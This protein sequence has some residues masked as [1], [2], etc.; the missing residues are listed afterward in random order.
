MLKWHKMRN[1]VSV[2]FDEVLEEVKKNEKQRFALLHMP[3]EAILSIKQYGEEA[4]NEDLDG[5]K[6]RDVG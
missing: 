2:S 6:D 3:P 4:D 1:E 5:P